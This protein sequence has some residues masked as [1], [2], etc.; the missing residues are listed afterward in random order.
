MRSSY[1]IF[2]CWSSRISR[3]NAIRTSPVKQERNMQNQTTHFH[4]FWQKSWECFSH[5]HS[6]SSISTFLSYFSTMW[7]S[8]HVGW[9]YNAMPIKCFHRI[10]I[11]KEL[12]SQ[13]SPVEKEAIILSTN[14]ATI[15][16]NAHQQLLWTQGSY[17]SWKTGKVQEFYSGIFQDWKA[18][19]KRLL[20][21]ERFENLLTSTKNMKC[22]T[23][24]KEN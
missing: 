23:G 2:L 10:C 5:F 19:E 6:H 12:R 22:M 20:V 3:Y 13:R 8:S 11:K 15:T 4:N 16:S 17:R 9:Q 1:C 14:S 18:L 24:S 7:Q 21:L